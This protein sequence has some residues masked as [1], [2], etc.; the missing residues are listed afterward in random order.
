MGL[1]WL[2]SKDNFFTGWSLHP[3]LHGL[4]KTWFNHMFRVIYMSKA[5]VPDVE[6]PDMGDDLDE[7]EEDV[8]ED[9]TD[10]IGVDDCNIE[11]V[12]DKRWYAKAAMLLDHLVAVLKK[13]CLHPSFALA[14]NEMMKRSK[15]TPDKL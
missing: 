4:T 9:E 12:I 10:D 7:E 1:V 13:M 6:E 5:A 14:V 3:P 8:D 15:G 11:R 2:P